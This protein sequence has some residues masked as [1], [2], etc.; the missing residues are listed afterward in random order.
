MTDDPTCGPRLAPACYNSETTPLYDSFFLSD[1]KEEQ[2]DI[3]VPT[4]HN[5]VERVYQAFGY[6]LPTGAD[7]I[8]LLAVREAGIHTTKKKKTKKGEASISPAE[9]EEDAVQDGVGDTRLDPTTR[10]ADMKA[11]TTV[12]DDLLFCVWTTKGPTRVQMAEVFR[13]TVDAGKR[14]KDALAMAIQCEGHL[15]Q[16]QPG[17]HAKRKGH[18]ALWVTSPPST[19]DVLLARIARDYRRTFID[20]SDAWIPGNGSMHGRWEF[21][22][23]NKNNTTIH[24]H[25]ASEAAQVGTNAKSPWSTG[26]TALNHGFDSARY[27]L[28]K[29]R[30]NS[31]ANKLKIPYLV[32]SSKYIRLYDE[33][34]EA[35]NGVRK[36]S[37]ASLIPENLREMGAVIRTGGLV[38]CPSFTS[39]Y[40]PSYMTEGFAKAV[41]AMADELVD[42]ANTDPDGA[43]KKRAA[44]VKKYPHCGV[45]LATASSAE[46]ERLAGVLRG[47]LAQASLR[48]GPH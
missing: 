18:V 39:G 42:A 10:E 47:S 32:V 38:P 5:W 26:C 24:V 36:M 19:S 27:L 8:A 31:A 17:Y 41:V 12:Y 4:V 22:V 35:L 45:N 46:L 14:D 44:L 34:L 40:L 2:L 48:L 13:C 21:C 1:V 43:T 15:Y 37:F 20:V 28:F 25:W 11:H 6:T 7:E 33:W 23:T 3:V 16:C 29:D 30:F 9:A